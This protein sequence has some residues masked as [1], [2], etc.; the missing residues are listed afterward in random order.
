MADLTESAA[1]VP[2]DEEGGY[3][4]PPEY[5]DTVREFS[6][7]DVP[8]LTDD[9]LALLEQQQFINREILAQ[10][11]TDVD[12]EQGGLP[13]PPG[14]GPDELPSPE[15]FGL[16]PSGAATQVG[17]LNAQAQATLQ[18]RVNQPSS[19]D[20]RVR[21]QLAT[22]ADYL[23]KASSPG[24]L[25]PLA[26]TDGVIFPYTPTIDT[27]YQAKYATSDLTHSNYKGYFYQSSSVDNLTVKGTFTAQDTREAQYLLAVI[28]FFRSVTKMFY[29]QD[30][31]AGAPPPLVYLSGFGQYQFNRLPCVVSNFAYNL[32]P[33][34]DYIRADGFNNYG[35]NLENRRS[36]SSGPGPGG[37]LGAFLLNKLNVNGLRLGGISNP[38]APPPVSQNVNNTNAVN[39]TYVPTKMDISVTLLPMQTRNQVSQQFSLKRFANGDLIKG[40]FW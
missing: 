39:S 11:A 7:E 22:G 6:A 25:K 23:Y 30:A 35:V 26:G 15:P 8:T 33:D 21:I 18:A 32:P 29:G 17:K 12:P 14:A 2:P 16:N 19:A 20:W 10:E 36:Q 13:L 4:P 9:E 24:I 3:P 31:Q 37:G 38:P 27:A 40:G 34:V 28:T 5:D 1:D